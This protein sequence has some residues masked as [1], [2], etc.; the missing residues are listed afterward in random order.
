MFKLC[1][2]CSTFSFYRV[3]K[4]CKTNIYDVTYTI[5]EYLNYTCRVLKASKMK[6]LKL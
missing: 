1:I 4:Y 3:G 2:K 6:L 5:N